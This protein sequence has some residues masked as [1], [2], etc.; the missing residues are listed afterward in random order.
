MWS[1]E[2]EGIE[3]GRLIRLLQNG[4]ALS[5]QDFFR[6]LAT[7]PEFIDWY[8]GLLANIDLEAYFWEFPA[9]SGNTLATPTEFAITDAPTLATISPQPGVFR[10]HFATAGQHA[11]AQFLSLGED[12]TLI[13][14]VPRSDSA[15]FPHLARF[16]RNANTEQSRELWLQTG[17]AMLTKLADL[18]ADTPLWLSTSGLGVGW[19]HI[20]L[21]SRPKYYQYAPYKEYAG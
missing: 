21:D 4:A 2:Q 8:N 3:N 14:P 9:L 20:R 5:Q 13:A 19:L 18:P 1:T 6:L 11:V 16:V 7:R 10:E 12:A 15:T 17:Q